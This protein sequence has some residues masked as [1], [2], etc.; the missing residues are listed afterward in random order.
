MLQLSYLGIAF[1]L[2][3]YVVFGIAVKFMELSNQTRNKARLA[4]I[5]GSLFVFAVSSFF[6]GIG[7]FGLERFTS[8]VI[9]IALSIAALVILSA[10][11]IELYNIT[12]RIRVRRFMVLFDIVDRYITEGK[13]QEEILTYLTD[14]QKLTKKEAND[15]LEFIQDPTNHQFLADVNDKIHEAQLLKKRS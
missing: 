8:G 6:A 14:I 15:F 12:K 13:T 1:A 2:V 9:F 10:I 7:S 3:F 5:I 4:I 11:F